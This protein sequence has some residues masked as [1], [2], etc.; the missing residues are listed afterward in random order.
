[1][2]QDYNRRVEHCI[3]QVMNEFSENPEL[4]LT[5]SDLKCRLFWALNSDAVFSRIEPTQDQTE[6]TNYVHSE[7]AYFVMGKLNKRRVDITVVK[8]SNYSFDLGEVATRYIIDRK[9][10][11]F[12]EPS[13]GIELKLNKRKTKSSMTRELRNVLDDLTLLKETRTESTFYLVF[14]DKKAKFTREEII[15][16]RERY[17]NIRIFY[18]F[19]P[20]NG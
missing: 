1:M 3:F 19:R 13:I 14:L 11:S 10:Y 4:F 12:D 17:P 18:T 6:R 20:L 5:E 7:T 9:G 2:P 16:W 15:S 8:P